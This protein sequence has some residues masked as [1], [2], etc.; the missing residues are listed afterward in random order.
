MPEKS[1]ILLTNLFSAALIL[2][3]CTA[4]CQSDMNDP[5][6]D[7]LVLGSDFFD[8]D[9]P[10]DLNIEFDLKEFQRTRKDEE[11]Q[12]AKLSYTNGEGR[13]ETFD[14]RLRTRG[15]FRKSYCYLPPFWI[16]IENSGIDTH[17]LEDIKKMKV[18]THCMKHKDFQD[19]VLKEYLVYKLYN[20]ISPYSF[21]VRLL[22]LTYI[23]TGRNNKE[24]SGW[25]FVIEP[26]ELLA[27]RLDARIVENE[28]LAMARMNAGLMDRLALF[29]Y[30]I[31]NTDFSVTGLHNMKI[32]MLNQPGPTG[33]VPIP[34][35]FDYTGFVNTVYA[36][37]AENV[38]IEKVTER[39]Y[40]GPCRPDAAY[41]QAIG[42]FREHSKEIHELLQSF[43][44]MSIDQ[45][46]DMLRF[47]EDFHTEIADEDF[48]NVHIRPTCR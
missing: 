36:R 14:V 37:P 21:K 30:M 19:Y 11:Y 1:S 29:Y 22:H 39:Y 32:I 45:K 10:I 7:S 24:M 13:K 44:L 42:E 12:R 18:V 48:I 9:E 26:I 2:F 34:Y 17:E 28:E 41:K 20:I 47:I 46:I 35:D 25:A 38:P 15:I 3:T 43:E 16:N 27:R 23:D 6:H 4:V 5:P 40:L 33:Y 31:G 8:R